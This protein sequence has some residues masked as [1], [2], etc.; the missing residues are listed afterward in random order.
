M[1]R[2]LA[3]VL[4]VFSAA[5]AA[6]AADATKTWEGTWDNKKT[7]S[8]GTL[9]CVAT[10]GKDGAWTATFSGLFLTEKFSSDVTFAEKPGKAGSALS[11][12]ADIRNRKFEWTGA[13][14]GDTLTGS[15]KGSGGWYGDF[16]LK[17]AKGK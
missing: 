11:G 5:T 4:L 2:L 10:K 16:V 3:A 7:G 1:T 13:L 14:K 8:K 9:K 12:A 15:Y 17:E 6:T